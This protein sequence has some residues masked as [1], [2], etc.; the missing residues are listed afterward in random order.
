ME[1]EIKLNYYQKIKILLSVKDFKAVENELEHASNNSLE[2]FW[3]LI[4]AGYS[5][6]FTI[7]NY[8]TL[9]KYIAEK[10]ISYN[11]ALVTYAFYPEIDGGMYVT[12]TQWFELN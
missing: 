11:D 10:S 7:S 2:A 9:Y 3:H 12:K 8:R 6:D 4:V 1:N 5:I